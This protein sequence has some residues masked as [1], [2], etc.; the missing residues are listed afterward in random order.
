MTK[1]HK[2]WV[3]DQLEAQGKISRN[4]ALRNFVTRLASR[5]ADLRQEG[6]EFDIKREE[7]DYVYYVREKPAPKPLELFNSF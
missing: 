7:G 1:T 4:Q 3:K 5:I 6:W 2:E